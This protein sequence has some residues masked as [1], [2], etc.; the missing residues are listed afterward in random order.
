MSVTG[1]AGNSGQDPSDPHRVGTLKT[2]KRVIGALLGLHVALAALMIGQYPALFRL[3][4]YLLGSS[5]AGGPR[6]P[7]MGVAVY[8]TVDPSGAGWR[9]V[10]PGASAYLDR[11]NR[12]LHAFAVWSP[13]KSGAY[14]LR[15]GVWLPSTGRHLR[16]LSSD[17]PQGPRAITIGT[18]TVV[19]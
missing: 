19:R 13:P 17:L 5:L 8:R 1:N 7:G 2:A 4:G 14:Q 18:L 12:S 11:P 9:H 16:V 10:V 6:Q 3:G 15:L